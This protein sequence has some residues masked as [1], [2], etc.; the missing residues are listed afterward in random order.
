MYFHG[1]FRGV[2]DVYMMYMVYIVYTCITGVHMCVNMVTQVYFKRVDKGMYKG[3]MI[4]C[5]I[6]YDRITYI[7]PLTV[8]KTTRHAR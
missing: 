8:L 1:V 5:P 6:Y 4:I 3:Y 2:F 7:I